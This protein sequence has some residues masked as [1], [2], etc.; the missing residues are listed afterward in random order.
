M[1]A[2]TTSRGPCAVAST[3]ES[4]SRDRARRIAC[5]RRTERGAH[6]RR[7]TGSRAQV[8][9]AASTFSS[10]P[11]LHLPDKDCTPE[12]ETAFC[13]RLRDICHTVGFF[14]VINH[15]IDASTTADAMNSSRAFFAL[16]HDVKQGIANIN[17]PAFRGYVRL[18]AEN[19]AGRPDWREQIEMGVEAD[20]PHG[21]VGGTH[22][23]RARRSEPVA[24]RDPMSGV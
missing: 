16:P 9:T 2:A 17:S 10:L 4:V 21:G 8:S 14:Y 13:C 12:E 1:S 23:R 18:G 3:S 19:T 24:G 5:S 7:A 15:G 22:L 20:A 11:V 6:P